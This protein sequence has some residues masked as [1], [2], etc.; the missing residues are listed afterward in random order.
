[1]SKKVLFVGDLRNGY[2]YGAIATSE[3]L[4]AMVE[5]SAGKENIKYI[6]VRS[7][8]DPTPVHG[9][10]KSKNIKSNSLKKEIAVKFPWLFK[11]LKNVKFKKND[12]TPFVA[13]KWEDYD[14]FAKEVFSG[15]RLQYEYSLMQWADIVYINGEGNIVKGTDE[16]GYYRIGGLYI[17][18]IAY[19]AKNHLNKKVHIVNHTV[20]PHNRDIEKIIKNLYPTLDSVFVREKYSLKKLHDLGVKHA[21]FVPDALFAYNP[22][23]TTENPLYKLCPQIDPGK[24]Y[25]CLGDSSGIYSKYNKVK[26]N[27]SGVYSKLVEELKKVVDQVVF[28]DGFNGRNKEIRKLIKQSSLPSVSLSTCSYKQ[29]YHILSNSELF[30]SGRW[31]NSI[32]SILSGTPILLWG[33]DSHKTVGL[34]DLL[35][36]PYEFFNIDSIPVH[37]N[38]IASEAKKILNESDK[39]KKS[40]YP[41][42]EQYKKDVYINASIL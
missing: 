36:Y 18:Y 17:L 42:V 29:L 34:Y 37:I 1:M 24:P 35:N 38:D 40:I 33:A 25:I 5:K 23:N 31:H 39:I 14:I 28:I 12:A 21:K 10:G 3:N 20:D 6:D 9:W 13:Y 27:V 4:C 15:K 16:N 41:L 30:I 8:R 2:N 7:L 22:E 11:L 26:W 32:L 19:L